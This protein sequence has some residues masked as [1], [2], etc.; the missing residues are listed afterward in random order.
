MRAAPAVDAALGS[1]RFERMV[2]VLLHAGAGV[3]GAAWASAHAGVGAAPVAP[4]LAG[5]GALAF[6]LA[7]AAVGGV[8]ARRALPDELAQLC[9]DGASWQ[10]RTDVLRPLGQVVVSMDLGAWV[11]LKLI[12][13]TGGARQ[14]RVA[15]ARSAGSSW[16][17]LRVALQAHGGA[18]PRGVVV[19]DQPSSHRSGDRS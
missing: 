5:S 15:G 10:L 8:L 19:Q 9:W 6:A 1:G 12:P 7:L 11:L 4:W 14:W 16:H 3:V 2:M 13:A 17:G 18:A